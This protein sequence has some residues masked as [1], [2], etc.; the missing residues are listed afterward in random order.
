MPRPRR[1]RAP[2]P[3][4]PPEPAEQAPAEPVAPPK[5]VRKRAP[6]KPAVADPRDARVVQA[7]YSA[8]AI[9]RPA[10]P[11]PALPARREEEPAEAAPSTL[12]DA[13]WRTGLLNVA[14]IARRELGAFFVSPI[15]YVIGALLIVVVAILGYILP[16]STGSPFSMTGVYAWVTYL[17][18]FLIPLFTMRLIAEERKTGTLEMLLTS[19][20]RDWELVVGKWLGAFVFYLA[21]TAFV[22]VFVVLSYVY[23]PLQAEVHPFG[24]SFHVAN[25][26]YGTIVT[27]YLG[28]VLA[29]AAFLAVGVLMSSLTSNQI[30]AAFGAAVVLIALYYL[31]GNLSSVISQPYGAFFDYASG[32]NRYLSFGEGRLVVKDVV[33]FLSLVVGALF[34]TTRVLESRKWR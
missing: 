29:G 24:L 31:L 17:M 9:A 2:R 21:I 10:L 14:A 16:V 1:R 32:Y 6:R 3:S 15:A 4:P 8:G 30:I 33:Y 19:P 27:G 7:T 20:V 23:T 12:Y 26:D 11:A 28:L 18:V 13:L 34:I 5:A 22:L 25:L